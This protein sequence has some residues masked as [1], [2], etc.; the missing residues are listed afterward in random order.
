V[1]PL[2]F[3]SKRSEKRLAR[4]E[5][6]PCWNLPQLINAVSHYLV[7]NR[8]AEPNMCGDY[9][10]HKQVSVFFP[11]S[12]HTR[13]TFRENLINMTIYLKHGSEYITDERVRKFRVKK[14]RHRVYKDKS[15]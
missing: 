7:F 13:G 12:T 15:G 5:A 14:V 4:E 1:N 6:N 8:R 11:E 2:E 3:E 9:I 10:T